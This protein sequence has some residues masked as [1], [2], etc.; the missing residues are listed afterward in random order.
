[1]NI[2]T[3][4]IYKNFFIKSFIVSI[5]IFILASII[6]SLDFNFCARILERFYEI[7]S[8]DFGQA[9]VMLFGI[10]KLLI[11]QFTLIPAIVLYW[12]EKEICRKKINDNGNSAE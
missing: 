7:E 3:V 5:V 9:F 6:S 2:E 10:W 8:D 4:R 12:I 1:M 11:I